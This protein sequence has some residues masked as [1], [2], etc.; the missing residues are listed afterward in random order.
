MMEDAD[1]CPVCG[2][3]DLLACYGM[4]FGGLG[5]YVVCESCDEVIYKELKEPGQCLHALEAVSSLSGR[6]LTPDPR[7]P[8][9]G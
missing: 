5:P 1:H 3:T 8:P 9:R 6:P 2:S 4:A 7:T